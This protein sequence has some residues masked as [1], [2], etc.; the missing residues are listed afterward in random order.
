MGTRPNGVT[1]EQQIELDNRAWDLRRKGYSQR[2]IAEELKVSQ[3]TIFRSLQRT[4]KKYQVALMKDVSALKGQQIEQLEYIRDEALEAWRKSQTDYQ[5]MTL[6]YQRV[7]EENADPADTLDDWR[8][9]NE[10][11]GEKKLEITTTVTRAQVGDPRYLK[12]A[13]EASAEIRKITGIDNNNKLYAL[14]IENFDWSKATPAQ[15]RRLES[16]EDPL[17]VIFGA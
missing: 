10:E 13:M 11:A 6:R 3:P 1:K 15:L 12:T 14:I 2:R 16:G 9:P 17:A 5:E 4:G 8:V 7:T